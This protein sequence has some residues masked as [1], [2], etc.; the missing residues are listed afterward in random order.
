MATA[1]AGPYASLHLAAD[2]QPCQHPTTQFF[3]GRMPFLPSQP[4]ASKHRQY[5]P[6]TALHMIQIH[7]NTTMLFSGYI[8]TEQTA[9]KHLARKLSVDVTLAI[10]VTFSCSDLQRTRVCL[11]FKLKLDNRLFITFAD[12]SS[13]VV[14]ASDCSVRGPTFESRR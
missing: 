1:S 7:K 13:R 3:T 12:L 5:R 8:L 2:R 9:S 11:T 14:S 6:I 10:L 4:T